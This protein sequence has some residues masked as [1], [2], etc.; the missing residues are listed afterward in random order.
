MPKALLLQIRG[1]VQGV[2]FRDS[3]RQVAQRLAL[4]G[5]VRNRQD[6]SVEAWVQGE[7][8]AVDEILAWAQHGPP[9][10]KVDQVESHSQEPDSAL[11]DFK[12]K[13]TV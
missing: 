13:E 3:M 2:F 12:R 1:K 4:S 9:S 7:E 11:Q 6:G 5:W 10:A 8:Q